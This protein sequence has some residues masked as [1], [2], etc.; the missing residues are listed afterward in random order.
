MTITGRSADLAQAARSPRSAAT[1]N[2]AARAGTEPD[3]T[4]P[5]AA[6]ARATTAA[7]P[8]TAATTEPATTP[9]ATAA[10]TSTA[11]TASVGY[12]HGAADVFPVENIECGK[13]DVEHFLVA[14]NEALI[15]RDVVRLR[16]AGSGRRGCGCSTHHRK[17]QPGGTQHLHCGGFCRAFLP[18]SLLDP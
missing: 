13:S 10:A 11:T 12:L 16:D 9:A 6:A 18:R 14:K 1:A 8:D 4:K 7:E 15:G 5:A 2:R 17:T 3:T